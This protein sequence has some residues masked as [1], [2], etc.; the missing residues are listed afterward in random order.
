MSTLAGH[1]GLE[2]DLEVAQLQVAI[3]RY[4]QFRALGF[5]QDEAWLLSASDADLHRARSLVKAGCPL[6]LALKIL[7]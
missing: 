5:E 7:A 1:H 4:D 6:P 3:W 2:A